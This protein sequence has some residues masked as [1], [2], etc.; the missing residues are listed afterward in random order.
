M[1]NIC[2]ASMTA[3]LLLGASVVE[4]KSSRSFSGT[5]PAEVKNNARNAGFEYP[6]GKMESP[7]SPRCTHR[8]GRD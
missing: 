2:R 3:L 1:K 4:A 8:R 7:P 6:D 5:N